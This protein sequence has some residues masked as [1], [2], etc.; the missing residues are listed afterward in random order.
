ME[1][2][3]LAGLQKIKSGIQVPWRPKIIYHYI[4]FRIEQKP[5]FIVDISDFFE[6]KMKAIYAH[7]SQFFNPASKEPQTMISDKGF[8]ELVRS[9]AREYGQQLGVRYGEGYYASRLI[10]VKDI[11]SLI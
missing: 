11:S 2:C 6:T 8:L 7:K 3:F 4:Q 1:S 9:R 10:G 5:D